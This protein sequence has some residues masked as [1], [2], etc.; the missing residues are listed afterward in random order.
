MTIKQLPVEQTGGE[1]TPTVQQDNKPSVD[2]DEIINE[3][4]KILNEN[5]ID[6][7]KPES[8]EGDTVVLKKSDLE[9]MKKANVNYGQGLKSLKTKAEAFK[10][11]TSSNP[12]PEEKKTEEPKKESQFLTRED[13]FKSND[14]KAIQEAC[15]EQEIEQNWDEIM[16]HF[17][18]TRS[19]DT[20]EN[21][22]EDIKDAHIIWKQRNGKSDNDDDK[23]HRSNLNQDRRPSGDT[24]QGGGQGTKKSVM[25]KT[26]KIQDWYGKPN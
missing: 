23:D 16:K 21:I 20:A 3:A 4:D 10:K 8:E 25:P 13:Y 5:N 14:S 19:R 9:K 11:G 26:T 15:K 6:D 24:G 2:P 12:K 7:I 18:R 17:R 22:L 1:Q